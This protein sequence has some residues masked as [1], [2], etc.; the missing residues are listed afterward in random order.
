VLPHPPRHEAQTS[1]S[2]QSCLRRVNSGYHRL[3]LL[4]ST[5]P[6]PQIAQISQTRIRQTTTAAH[7]PAFL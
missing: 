5:E 4:V 6:N 2:N 7:H 3:E 1:C